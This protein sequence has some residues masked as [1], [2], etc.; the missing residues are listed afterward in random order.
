MVRQTLATAAIDQLVAMGLRK[1][2]HGLVT[3]VQ[4]GQVPSPY[5]S[6]ARYGA[7]Q[8]VSPPLAV[9]RIA[10]SDGQRVPAPYRSH[11]TARVEHE[12][13]A[14]ATCIGR[15]VPHTRPKGF[16]RLRYDGVQATKTCAKV[17]VLL[18]EA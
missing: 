8:V 11:R 17:K 13:V 1:Y 7:T 3:N 18:Q 6:L 2:P 4:K 15:M 5:Q 14:V 16:K 12:T 9:R 10:R